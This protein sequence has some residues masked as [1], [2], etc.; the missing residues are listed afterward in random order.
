[1]MRKLLIPCILALNVTCAMAL[2]PKPIGE[3]DT[4]ALT[5]ETQV[6]PLQAGDDHFALAWWIPV[7]FWEAI[8][9]RDPT[10][11]QADKAAMLDALS[12]VSLLA[13]VQADISHFGA[14]DFYSKA[15]IEQDLGISYT[16][17]AGGVRAVTLLKRVAPDLQVILSTFTPLLGAAMGN[18]GNNM[19][20]YVL[21]DS[22]PSSRRTLDPYREGIIT[23]EFAKRN[24][25]PM[26]ADIE[27][28]LNSLFIPRKCPN[29]KDAH[30]SWKYCPWTGVK[31]ED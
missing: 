19:H 6:M 22:S 20:F 16:D 28:P 3:V 26:S 21:E 13:V 29:G 4:D 10:T 5:T 2:D 23:I 25:D 30:V 1:M 12:Q 18:L 7:E 8:L 17:A 11:S 27:M 14:F 31:L 15:E 24:G 9:A